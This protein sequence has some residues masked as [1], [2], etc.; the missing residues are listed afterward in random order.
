MKWTQEEIEKL[1]IT[2][3]KEP[4]QELIKIFKRGYVAIKSKASE[5][6]IERIAKG[7]LA[8][9]NGLWKGDMVGKLALHDWIKCHKPQLEL[10]EECKKVPPRDLANISGEYKRDINDFR[11]LCRRCHMLSDGRLDIFFSWSQKIKLTP[12]E[13][14]DKK[15]EYYI[16]NKD[17]I[18]LRMKKY[19]LNN[20]E[21]INKQKKEYYIKNKNTALKLING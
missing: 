16:K 1:K 12:E 14:K 6:K 21:K 17:K 18:K 4:K 15:K 13:R 2:Y 7:N 5:L 19:Y 3:P 20:C 8:E 11:W 9:N 10:C